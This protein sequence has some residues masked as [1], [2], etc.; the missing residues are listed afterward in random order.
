MDYQS[1]KAEGTREKAINSAQ[2]SLKHLEKFIEGKMFFGGET[3]C[4]LYLKVG[5]LHN[6]LR[7]LEESKDK[8]LSDSEKF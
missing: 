2:E 6:W 4:L 8:K 5:S 3:M 7:F 1:Y